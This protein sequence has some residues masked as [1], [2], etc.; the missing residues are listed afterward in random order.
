[1]QAN[2]YVEDQ[3]TR[4]QSTIKEKSGRVGEGYLGLF[5]ILKFCNTWVYGYL[6]EI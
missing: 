2:I 6:S 4:Q 5:G 1:M 3:Y